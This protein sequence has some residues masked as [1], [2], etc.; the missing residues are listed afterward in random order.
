MRERRVGR[1][2]RVVGTQREREAEESA[3][4]HEESDRDGGDSSPQSRGRSMT[5]RTGYGGI[6]GVLGAT[7][8]CRT[9]RRAVGAAGDKRVSL[10][11]FAVAWHF[12]RRPDALPDPGAS[13]LIS[14][15]GAPMPVGER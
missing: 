6:D 3:E 4:D 5:A 7:F 14:L 13:L 9:P 2:G 12:H 10:K 8:H 15:R 11:T 1:G